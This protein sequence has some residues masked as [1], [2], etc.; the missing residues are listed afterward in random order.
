[1]LHSILISASGA[2]GGVMKKG[3]GGDGGGGATLWFGNCTISDV[4]AD[5]ILV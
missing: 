1:M 3:G 2:V 4:V 5:L